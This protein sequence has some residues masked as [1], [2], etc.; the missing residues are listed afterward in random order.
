MYA[1]VCI[2]TLW[3]I[4]LG[5]M[6]LL[7]I[8]LTAFLISCSTTD[9]KK[10]L[11][12]DLADKET[13]ILFLSKYHVDSVP[14]DIGRLKNTKRLYI[15]DD[16]VGWTIYPPVS[17]LP[18][19]TDSTPGKKLPTEITDLTGLKYLGLVHLNLESLPEDFNKLKNL[20]TL[21]LSM[22]KLV[23]SNELKKLKELTGLK[24]LGLMGNSIDS[25]D[26][27][28]LKINNPSLTIKTWVE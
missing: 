6:R 13:V 24:Y 17:A 23:I 16:S 4:I 26:I 20:D 7:I 2:R 18:Q 9:E 19:S 10:G 25:A 1:I 11:F 27:K 15:T 22:N 28:E 14:S 3:D 21:D 8:T 5:Q 12:D